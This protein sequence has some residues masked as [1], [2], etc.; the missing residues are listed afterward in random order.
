MNL[1]KSLNFRNQSSVYFLICNCKDRKPVH[2]YLLFSKITLYCKLQSAQLHTMRKQV[3]WWYRK[4]LPFDRFQGH[5]KL[6]FRENRHICTR[7]SG[8]ISS[9]QV[10]G[11]PLILLCKVSFLKSTFWNSRASFYA[12]TEVS[13]WKNYLVCL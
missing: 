1:I 13:T 11:G 12:I 9:S 10:V 2:I 7:F 5:D 6:I 4:V 8:S 3:F